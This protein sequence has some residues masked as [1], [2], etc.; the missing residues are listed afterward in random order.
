MT[1]PY[2][3]GYLHCPCFWGTEPGSFVKL[4]RLYE[5]SFARLRVLDAGCGE[6]KNAVFLAKMGAEVDAIDISEIAVQN[7]RRRWIDVPDV[8]WRVADVRS[9][10]LPSDEYEVVICYGL[11]H[12]LRDKLDVFATVSRLQQLTTLGGYHVICAFN[13]RRQELHDAHPGF[14]PCL[15]E[16]DQY[17]S[18]YASW[19]IL[20]SSDEDLKEQH[21]H[22]M[23]EHTHSLTRLLAR[24]IA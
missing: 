8:H 11:F 16:H 4:L 24:R 23:V 13:D 19:Q 12:C 9:A 21:P 20:A 17:L 3:E 10:A 5:S 14:D 15:L 18:A 2:D 1:G 7:G 22:N 6:G